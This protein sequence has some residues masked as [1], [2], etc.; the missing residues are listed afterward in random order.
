MTVSDTGKIMSILSAAYPQFYRSQSDD[1]RQAALKL[2]AA[3]FADDNPAIVI[4][5]VQALIA[6]DEKGFPPHIGAVK[7][8]IRL[9]TQPKGM[10]EMEAWSLVSKAVSRTRWEHPEEQYN[11]LP[12]NI[13]K[14]LG[15][16]NT[17][18]E[19]GMI[20]IDTFNT[21]TQSNFMR[22]FRTISERQ[23]ELSSLPENVKSLLASAQNIKQLED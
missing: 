9:I 19:W 10:S 18:I 3:M 1:E 21:V 7:A 23:K 4:A 15:S 12:E 5:A 13:Q 2:W 11:L 17:L 16:P 6:T 22:S 14:T 20:D 8:K